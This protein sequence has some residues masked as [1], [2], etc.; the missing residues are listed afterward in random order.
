MGHNQWK[1][2]VPS[3]EARAFISANPARMARV[4]NHDING[5]ICEVGGC[6][7]YDLVGVHRISERINNETGRDIAKI[8]L[9]SRE[10]LSHNHRPADDRSLM[11]DNQA[12][13]VGAIKRE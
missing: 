3:N 10:T 13:E 1:L 9:Q 7:T 4:G 8:R 12:M 5:L 2:A 6:G 11:T